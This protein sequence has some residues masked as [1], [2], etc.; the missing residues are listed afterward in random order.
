[1]EKIS[2]K[3]VSNF[4]HNFIIQHQSVFGLAIAALKNINGKK[5]T[6][7]RRCLTEKERTIRFDLSTLR[8]FKQQIHQHKASITSCNY[9]K[10]SL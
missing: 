3:N 1:M 7:L 2:H 6:A 4:S 10:L 9:V 8:L 5:F